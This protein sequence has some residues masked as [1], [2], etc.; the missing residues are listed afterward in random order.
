[1]R[2]L[3]AL[4]APGG[5]AKAAC[6][7]E[8]ENANH[9]YLYT[10][11]LD[12]IIIFFDA[13]TVLLPVKTYAHV[14]IDTTYDTTS[15]ALRRATTIHQWLLSPRRCPCDAII[16]FHVRNY[17]S[18]QIVNA[19]LVCLR[20]ALHSVRVHKQDRHCHLPE[21]ELDTGWSG[22]LRA[23]LICLGDVFDKNE[24]PV[25]VQIGLMRPPGIRV[26]ELFLQQ[27]LRPQQL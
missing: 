13:S 14:A 1:M 11:D 18:T 7:E 22:I 17:Y 20:I 8:M 21:R 2:L 6:G 10:T 12:V 24:P 3:L 26:L 9:P 23:R 25:A 15:S 5:R 27:H 4:M 19:R 16:S